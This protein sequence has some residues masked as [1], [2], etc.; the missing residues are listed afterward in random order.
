M[1]YETF[2]DCTDGSDNNVMSSILVAVYILLEKVK[3]PEHQQF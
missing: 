1:I 2:K 3:K